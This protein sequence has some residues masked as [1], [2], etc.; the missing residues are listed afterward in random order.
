M[1]AKVEIT[2]NSGTKLSNAE[3]RGGKIPAHLKASWRVLRENR[4]CR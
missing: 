2:F 1:P 3:A 4:R